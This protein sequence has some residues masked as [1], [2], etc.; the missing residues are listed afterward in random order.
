MD[1]SVRVSSAGSS[2]AGCSCS[3]LRGK[4][5]GTE[6]SLVCAGE[7]SVLSSKGSD[8]ISGAQLVSQLAATLKAVTH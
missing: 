3:R 4:V 7:A 8:I 5:R 1:I 6:D 2:A